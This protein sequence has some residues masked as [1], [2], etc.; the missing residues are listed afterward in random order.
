LDYFRHLRVS[1]K[2]AQRYEIVVGHAH[3]HS[4]AGRVQAHC[5]CSS[6]N[7]CCAGAHAKGI[8]AICGSVLIRVP[9]AETLDDAPRNPTKMERIFSVVSQAEAADA[10]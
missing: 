4:S 2:F 9:V 8:C 6:Q 5:Q 7:R 3:R 10:D 1:L